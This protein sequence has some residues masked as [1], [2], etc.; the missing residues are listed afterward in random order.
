[1]RINGRTVRF[2][3]PRQTTLAEQ[4]ADRD[5]Q[6]VS[7]FAGHEADEESWLRRAEQIDSQTIKV[8]RTQLCAALLKTEWTLSAETKANIERLKDPRTLVIVGGQQTGL[9]GGPLLVIYKALTAISEARRVERLLKRSV[10]PVF[11][12]ASEDHD[13]DEVNHAFFQTDLAS[14]E[15]LKVQSQHHGMLPVGERAITADEWQ[16]LREQCA[17]FMRDTEFSEKCKRLLDE[18]MKPGYTLT[19][20]CAQLLNQLFGEY[21]LIL[22]DAASPTIRQLESEM[23][24]RLFAS[25]HALSDAFADAKDKLQQVGHPSQVEWQALQTHLFL[26]MDHKRTMLYDAACD[27]PNGEGQLVDR[28]GR[29]LLDEA[30]FRRIAAEESHRLSN[31]VLTRPLMQQFLLPAV[32]VVL[33]RAELSYWALLPGAF[34]LLEL[35]LPVM[36]LRRECT[37]IEPAQERSMVKYSLDFAAVTIDYEHTRA[38][39]L[40]EQDTLQLSQRFARMRVQLDEWYQSLFA[41]LGQIQAS[42]VALA[43]QN[44]QKIADQIN[45]LEK[46]SSAAL[47]QRH[48]AYLRQ[49]ERLHQSLF[50]LGKFQERVYNVCAYINRNGT[51]WIDGILNSMEHWE[52][53]RH[54]L[55]FLSAAK[56]ENDERH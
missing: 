52:S 21:G 5:E 23:F 33:G 30:E 13:W 32:G 44:R 25:R 47:E 37:L 24:L 43:E 26:T 19:V 38:A 10:V 22:L 55:V 6:A 54:Y 35:P 42:L 12:L 27:S 17:T 4:Y 50:P 14:V 39:W 49:L 3:W 2:D 36:V 1:M 51:D 34:A 53:G 7:V 48:E 46:R 20:H 9:L 18:S 29:C 56:E 40:A 45:Y 28:L 11:W 41:D 15:K 16:R 8:D 31:N